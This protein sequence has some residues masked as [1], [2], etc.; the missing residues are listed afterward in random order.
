MRFFFTHM[1]VSSSLPGRWAY[2]NGG[3]F[4]LLISRVG[5]GNIFSILYPLLLNP[6]FPYCIGLLCFI[7]V[8]SHILHVVFPL[9]SFWFVYFQHN[10]CVLVVLLW[11]NL[12]LPFKDSLDD[13]VQTEPLLGIKEMALPIFAGILSALRR[14]IARRVSLKVLN[15]WYLSIFSYLIILLL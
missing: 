8:P 13:E 6:C 7:I 4:L 12:K 5:H 10:D 1:D 11:L 2:C 14:V 3:I 9:L 15:C